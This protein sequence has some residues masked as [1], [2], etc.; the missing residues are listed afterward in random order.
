MFA[1]KKYSNLT[2]WVIL[3]TDDFWLVKEN[4]DWP[5]SQLL[6]VSKPRPVILLTIAECDRLD[7]NPSFLGNDATATDDI[8]IEFSAW[9]KTQKIEDQFICYY[10]F[11]VKELQKYEIS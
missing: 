6:K 5:V 11:Y 2:H 3:I 9:K 10:K 1:Y 7:V 8:D 4:K